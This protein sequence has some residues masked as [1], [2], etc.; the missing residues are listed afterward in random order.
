MLNHANKY[1]LSSILVKGNKKRLFSLTLPHLNEH[2]KKTAVVTAS[3]SD[4]K[5]N[6]DS[7]YLDLLEVN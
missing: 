5:Y 6:N 1:T 3:G 4:Y 2:S 7:Y